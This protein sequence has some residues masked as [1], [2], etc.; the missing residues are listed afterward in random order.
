MIEFKKKNKITAIDVS[1]WT[2][3]WEYIC[4]VLGGKPQNHK[5]IKKK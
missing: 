4:W 2:I 5:I 3:M 1:I